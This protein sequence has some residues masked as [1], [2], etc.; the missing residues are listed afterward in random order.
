M[1]RTI[2]STPIECVF[3]RDARALQV[4]HAVAGK[5]G[6]GLPF[7][8]LGAGACGGHLRGCHRFAVIAP[9]AALE[10]DDVGDFGIAEHAGKWRHGAWVDHASRG[11]ARYS[12]EDCV[13]VF[14]CIV[15]VD[16]AAAFERRKHSG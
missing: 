10:I 5:G 13:Y 4:K 16:D 2:Y 11:A 6:S 9:R 14:R 7:T 8:S 15:L 12:I 3:L 1:S